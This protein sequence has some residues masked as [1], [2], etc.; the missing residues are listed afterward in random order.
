M[1]SEP[2]LCDRVNQI[3]NI[4]LNASL[5]TIHDLELR[6][7][8]HHRNDKI[9]S[10]AESI[11]LRIEQLESYVPKEVKMDSLDPKSISV[12]T[13][14]Q[15]DIPHSEPGNKESIK[16][17]NSFHLLEEDKSQMK[18]DQITIDYK[19]D[20]IMFEL[21]RVRQLIQ[22]RPTTSEFQLVVLSLND[23]MNK[24]CHAD[25]FFPILFLFLSKVLAVLANILLLVLQLFLD[26]FHVIKISDSSENV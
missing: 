15:D 1:I 19:I 17:D 12:T 14:S 2:F 25:V 9:P 3:V 16:E 7:S 21:E 23:V 10:W 13:P 5:I 4:D 18:M 22:F 26:S 6:L 20:S 8:Q 24:M 11:I